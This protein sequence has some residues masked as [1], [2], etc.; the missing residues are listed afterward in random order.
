MTSS[1]LWL[2]DVMARTASQLAEGLFREST[3]F[4]AE[5]A[6]FPIEG[7]LIGRVFS[8]GKPVVVAT[9]LGTRTDVL[10][11]RE[12]FEIRSEGIESGLALPLNSRDRTVGVMTL[13]SQAGEFVQS[14]R[15]W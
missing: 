10:N 8:T 3:G 6:V 5:D 4:T 15:C 7:S 2:P 12:S 14:G 13:G 1:G 9:K 11:E